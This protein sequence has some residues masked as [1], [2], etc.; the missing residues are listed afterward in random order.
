MRTLND[1]LEDICIYWNDDSEIVVSFI[2]KQL[3]VLSR[4]KRIAQGCCQ[5]IMRKKI[6]NLC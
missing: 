3:N 6:N 5:C 4:K 2:E 1:R